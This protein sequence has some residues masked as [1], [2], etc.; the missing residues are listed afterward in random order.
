MCVWDVTSGEE[1]HTSQEHPGFA[2][3]PDGTV[4]VSAGMDDTIRLWDTAAYV[5]LAEFGE[6]NVIAVSPDR[7]LI[8]S[9]NESGTIQLWG[10]PLEGEQLTVEPE[11]A[12]TAEATEPG[13]STT[14]EVTGCAWVCTPTLDGG[15]DTEITC[16]SGQVSKTMNNSTSIQYVGST[17]IDT[18]NVDETLTYTNTGHTYSVSG[19]V[20]FV[21]GPVGTIIRDYKLTVSGGAFGEKSQ[22]CSG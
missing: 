12:V 10:V 22:T 15:L 21:Q 5:P 7:S 13:T 9:G 8:A 3:S 1:L 16:E 20:T 17:E 11:V 19:T 6:A 4:L 2:F 18:L 14:G